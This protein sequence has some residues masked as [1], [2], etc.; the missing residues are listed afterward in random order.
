MGIGPLGLLPEIFTFAG[1]LAILVLGS[2]LPQ[3]RLGWTRL[4]ASA[5]L[6]GSATAAAVAL[7]GPTQLLYSGTFIA[8]DLTNV[9]RLIAT[10]ASL[11]VV[12]LAGD[13]LRD[14]PRASEAYVLLLFS[15]TGVLLLAGANDLLLLAV[16]FL[17]ASI[18][19]YGLIGLLPGKAAAEATL[20]TYLMGA[21]FGILMFLGVV[22]LY[23]LAADTSYPGLS[24]KLGQGPPAAVGVAAVLVITGL[25]FKAG[26]VP[27]HFWVPDAAEG[28]AGFAATFLTT[29]PKIGA[30][31]ALYR[32]VSTLPDT[33][34]WSLVIAGLATLSMTLGN[35][36]ALRQTDPRRLLGYSTVS[37]VGYLLVPVAVATRTELAVPA[38]LL[39]LGGY[40]VTNIAAFAV[41]VAL[42][43]HR[44]IT[45]YRGLSRRRPWL[46]GALLISL[47]GLLG[48]PP[49]AVFV[50]KLTVSVAAWQG[51]LAWL[52]VVLL[53]N[54]LI[55]LGY[56]LPWFAAAFTKATP[57]DETSDA[58]GS[59][60]NSPESH[61]P[62]RWTSGVALGAAAVSVALGLAAGIVWPLI[63]G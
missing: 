46:A 23:G 20:K 4:A 54:T 36:A 21:M 59:D 33:V 2:F 16:A 35:L 62:R 50:G 14:H 47:L 29:I 5:V 57:A 3:R 38:M 60:G 12:L 41:V 13:E 18:P 58:T 6:L 51:G 19:L 27:A 42:P 17:L 25:L 48:T 15:T 45:D 11:L 10:L 40:A 28:S 49:A 56:Y 9:T 31:V 32:F 24:A 8:D 43:Q 39:Y 7:A 1:G 53:I 34:D 30:I 63:A 37:Q 26:G 61:D 44:S 52:V 55:S 22:V